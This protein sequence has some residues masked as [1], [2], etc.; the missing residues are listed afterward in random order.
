L[1]TTIV[2]SGATRL[3]ADRGEI[4]AEVVLAVPDGDDE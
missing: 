4:L 3:L 1:S 2:S